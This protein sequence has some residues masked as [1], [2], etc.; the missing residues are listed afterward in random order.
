MNYKTTLALLLMLALVGGYYYVFERDQISG[1]EARQQQQADLSEKDPGTPVF[2]DENLT[3]SAI[4]RIDITRSGQT[5]SMVKEEGQWLQTKPVRFALESYAPSAIAE[6]FV[7]LRYLQRYQA[8]DPDAPT[9]EQMGLDE[10]RA[11]VTVLAGEKSWTLKLGKL[12]VGRRGYV[13]IDGDDS[14]YAV[15]SALHGAVLDENIT[16]WRS[17]SL[18]VP[19]ASGVERIGLIQSDGEIGLNRIDG[20]WRIQSSGDGV[21]RASDEAVA[22]FVSA[23]DRLWISDFTE[24]NPQTLRLYGLD[25]PYLQVTLQTPPM[26][27]DAGQDAPPVT[28]TLTIGNATLQGA[29]RYATWTTHGEPAGVVFTV[30]AASAEGLT[31]SIDELRDPRAIVASQRD[32]RELVVQQNGD[33]TLHLLRDPQAGYRFGGTDPGYGVDFST[34][35]ALTESLCALESTRFT[36][37]LTEL[38]EP[39]ASVRLQL[40]TG[41]NERSFSVYGSGEDRVIVTEGES[42]G[43]LVPANDLKNLLGATLGLRDRT[44]LELPADK[45]ASIRLRRG[46]EANYE[47]QRTADDPGWELVGSERFESETLDALLRSL[48]PL[49]VERWLDTPASADNKPIELTIEPVVG[50]TYVL[51]ADGSGKAAALD[52]L[53]AGFYLSDGFVD[54][55]NAEYLDRTV[56]ALTGEQISSVTIA[57]AETRVTIT[58]EGQRFVSED[59]EPIDQ[60]IAAGV[61]DALAGLRAERYV[62]PLDLQPEDIDF[63][64]E[65]TAWDD[66]PRAPAVLRFVG[67]Q[68]HQTTVALDELPVTGPMRWFTLNPETMGRLRA[69]L[70]D[71]E[72]MIK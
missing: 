16:Q 69:P 42:V 6:N 29:D 52:G 55:L 40:A 31:R 63:T 56:L 8:G 13:Q 34:A 5:A 44:L 25:E 22:G 49:R 30:N 24:D 59:G 64:V 18:N 53:D 66:Y 60:V 48:Y 43:Y 46:S 37:G 26:D 58:R 11:V 7:R 54:L 36:T 67:M 39:I 41:D 50:D 4:D 3:V 45:I 71:V 72:A 61:F 20:R 1:Y 17:K 21:Q 47:F 19:Q 65:L 10:P 62:G 14:I 27:A 70:S 32:I 23:I 57:D 12:S 2:D 38:G 28:H 33:T 9:T 68:G 51:R 35:N 15:D